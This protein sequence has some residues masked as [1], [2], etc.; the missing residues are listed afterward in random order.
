[1][2]IITFMS[3][4]RKET[5]QTLSLAAVAT[6]LA[7]EH[8]YKILIVATGFQDKILEDCFWHYSKEQN[9]PIINSTEMRMNA[10]VGVD[11]GVEGLSRVLAGNRTSP[12]IV[13]NYSKIIL[14]DRL[15]VLA[16]PVTTDYKEYAEIT[17]NYA[18]ILQTANQF[19]D[20]ILVDLSNRMPEQSTNAILQ[21]SNVN[22]VNITQR[23]ESIDN[24]LQLRQDD[25]FYKRKNIMLLVGRYDN[26]SKYNIKNITRYLKER[27]EVNAI[28]YNTLFFE[29]CAEA[30]IIDLFLN[31]R[32][33]TDETDRNYI[34]IK[35]TKSMTDALIYR[36]QELQMKL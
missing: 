3:H 12:E 31:F 8:N 24:F 5:G 30:K 1:M 15:D 17:K 28:P 23:L 36:L 32:N 27:K 13:R 11:S 21:M 25:D 16:S 6:Q 22:V 7:I 29:A 4:E 2:A 20:M 34:F 18:D 10:K 33:I 26:F 14:K 19:Y 9:T 35:E